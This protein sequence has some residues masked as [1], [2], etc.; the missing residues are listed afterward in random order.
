V[1]FAN[2]MSI[3][4]IAL[5][6]LL[7]LPLQMAAQDKAKQH[8][9]HQYHHYQL[10]D[11]G[12]FGGPQSFQFLGG[13]G[14]PGVLSNQGKFAGWADTSVIDPLCFFD[15]PDR[16]AAHAFVWQNG[17]KTDLGILPGGLNSQVNWISANGLA[18]GVADNGQMDPLQAIPQ[19]R[20]TFWDHDGM[21]TDVGNLPGAYFASPF[22]VNSRGEVAGQASNTIPNPYSMTGL[23]YQSR[24]IYWKDGAMQDLGTLGSGTDAY[25]GLINERGQVVGVSYISTIPSAFCAGVGS[26]FPLATG[27]FIWD[28]KNGMKDI[29]SFGGTCTVACDLNNRGQVVGQSNHPDDLAQH[30][31]IWDRATGIVELPTGAGIYGDSAA[32]NDDGEIVGEADAPDG[33]ASA[34]LWR[35]TGGK[36]KTTYLGRLHS[37]VCARAQ[38]INASGQVV[39][40]SGPNGCSILLPFLWED[41]G[42]MVDLN[43]LVPPNSGLQLFE[44][45]QINDRGE[46]TVNASDAN[47]NNY[48]VLLIPCDEN[49]PGVEGCDYDLID[50]A[51]AA[52]RVSQ[53]PAPT[54]VSIDSRESHARNAKPFSFSKESADS[55]PRNRARGRSQ[56][57]APC[58]ARLRRSG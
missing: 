57:G 36:W 20:G 25:A 48:S 49:H 32:I 26:G 5:L 37:G 13:L 27:S 31:F 38:S 55:Q 58:Q 53:D 40:L 15:V 35:K 16:Y 22:A 52:A 12:T 46:I 14:A 39:G 34:T 42:P 9:P 24:A 50:A 4:A 56:P 54:L 47:G 44:A 45:G 2:G 43:A 10:V 29:G 51:T 21:I 28:K 33:Q 17:A 30:P 11:V 3:A 7:V 23:G 41:G 19:M 8:Q 18:T 1:R 6:T